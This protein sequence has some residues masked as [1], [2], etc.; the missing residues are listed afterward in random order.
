M[1]TGSPAI[2]PNKRNSGSGATYRAAAEPTD[3]GILP[4]GL[5]K[6]GYKS[7]IVLGRRYR[8]TQ[9][10]IEGTAVALTFYQHGCERASIEFVVQGKIEIEGFDVPRLVDAETTKE[11]ENSGRN[12]GP[13]DAVPR[14]DPILR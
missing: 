8:D 10:G 9:T 12:G 5:G 2:D 7:G 3:E 6:N 11:P 4:M 1:S 13:R 14:R